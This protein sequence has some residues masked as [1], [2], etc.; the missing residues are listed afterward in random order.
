MPRAKTVKKARAWLPEQPVLHL[1]RVVSKVLPVLLALLLVLA[2][3]RVKA[4]HPARH[5]LLALSRPALP[6]PLHNISGTHNKVVHLPS[7]V[8][9]QEV[10][11]YR[12]PARQR[13]RRR[14]VQVKR[15][16]LLA[17]PNPSTRR[18]LAWIRFTLAPIYLPVDWYS[19]GILVNAP[20]SRQKTAPV[21][22]TT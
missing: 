14:S 10:M 15:E 22:G 18:C 19:H 16:L 3:P 1:A 21:C 8:L 9:L 13:Q 17:R 2:L 20:F 11:H 5:I 4:V 7:P 6:S 12:S